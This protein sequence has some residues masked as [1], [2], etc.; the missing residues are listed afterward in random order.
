[1]AREEF[2]HFDA[3][4]FREDVE[5]EVGDPAVFSGFWRQLVPG[6]LQGELDAA[7]GGEEDVDFA[8]LDFLEVA[9]GELGSFSQPFLGPALPQTLAADV[10]AEKLQSGPLFSA[11]WHDIIRRSGAEIW[12]DTSYREVFLADRRKL[13]DCACYFSYAC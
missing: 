6:A 8:G 10:C 5:I 1:M 3:E 12:N 13:K 2:L 9:G 4:N 11:Q 7:G